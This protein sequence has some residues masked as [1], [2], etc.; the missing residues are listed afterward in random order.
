VDALMGVGDLPCASA[1]VEEEPDHEDVRVLLEQFHT[2]GKCYIVF[3]TTKDADS[4]EKRCESGSIV[5][6]N[7]RDG[8]DYPI[9]VK[10]TDQE[11]ITILWKGHGTDPGE[12]HMSIVKGILIVLGAVLILDLVFYAPYVYYITSYT[13]VEGMSQGNY[14]PFMLL[15]LLITVCNQ[16][17][18]QIIG[19][20]TERQGWTSSDAKACFYMTL[21]TFA[22]YLNTL[23]DVATVM[24]LAQ[25]YSVDEAWKREV[26]RDSTISTKALA[27]SPNVQEAIYVQL[28]LYITPGCLIFP[29]IIEPFATAVLPYFL[30]RG[31]VR[32][33]AEVTTQQAEELMQCM[34]YDL[35]R[36][37]D[38]LV[39]MLLICMTLVF[40]YQDVWWLAFNFILSNII[41]YAWDQIRL[42]RCTTKTILSTSMVDDAAMYMLSVPCGTIAAVI[43]FKIYAAMHK[44]FLEE[45]SRTHHDSTYE[46]LKRSTIIPWCSLGFIAHVVL[47]TLLLRYF[48]RRRAGQK[49]RERIDKGGRNRFAGKYPDVA[50]AL[51]ANYFNTN[52]IH[53]LRSKYIKKADPPCIF[54]RIGRERLIKPNPKLGLYFE[55]KDHH[56]VHRSISTL[57]AAKDSYSGFVSGSR[58]YTGERLSDADLPMEKRDSLAPMKSEQEEASP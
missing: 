16:A 52:P 40:V 32:T 17:I 5:Y 29:F 7:E 26:A 42:L 54:Y 1:K 57:V 3:G 22:V 28:T 36:Y 55:G 31:L 27:E 19:V 38:L 12:F 46:L 23:I 8:K 9:S 25:G 21:Y 53:C 51:P 13:S 18:Y 20:I 37:G 33:R 30:A 10:S 58:A 43:V 4:A 15:G 6:W 2:I 41:I 50:R 34:P 35:S 24:L 11:P 48:I 44:G 49:Q 14:W 39:N 56:S 47:H 45:L